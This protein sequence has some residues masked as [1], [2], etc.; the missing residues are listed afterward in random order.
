MEAEK[1]HFLK[2]FKLFSIKMTSVT[3]AIQ[4]HQ[5]ALAPMYKEQWKKQNSLMLGITGSR[6]KG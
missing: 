3:N 2:Y 6:S 4:I 1:R 5:P